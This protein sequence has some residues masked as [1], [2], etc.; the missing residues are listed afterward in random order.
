ML[1]FYSNQSD[2]VIG[3]PIANRHY[4]QVENLIGFFVNAIALRI[5]IDS[6]T[7][8][9]DFIRYVNQEVIEAQIHQDLPFEKL[10]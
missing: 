2:L 4:T 1:K 10:G 9:K 6:K 5:K 7:L 3:I 8:I